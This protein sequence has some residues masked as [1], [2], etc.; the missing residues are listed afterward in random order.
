MV[1]ARILRAM[2]IAAVLALASAARPALAAGLSFADLPKLVALSA[3]QISPDGRSIVVVVRR[4]DYEHDRNEHALDIVDVATARHRTLTVGRKGVSSPAWSPQ[5]DR[6]AFLADVDDK[7]QIFVMPMNG[8]DAAR[9][10]NAAEGVEQFAWRPDG[11]AFA[12]VAIDEAP[13][14][15]G[16][17][18][19][20]DAFKV[21]NNDYLRRHAARSGHIY[22]VDAS[23]G[24]ARR[25]TR[26]AWSVLV[27]EPSST[28]SWSH[29]GKTIAFAR[30][31]NAI[32]DTQDFS[33]AWLVD[34]A[35]GQMHPLTRHTAWERDPLFSAD[36]TRVAFTYCEGD[37]QVNPRE[38]YVT[39]PS[40]GAETN[41]TRAVDRAVGDFA[42]LPDN[43]AL[44]AGVNDGTANA[45]FRVPL[46]GKAARIDLHGVAIESSLDGAIAKDGGIAFVGSTPAW[47]Q[48]VYYAP[49]GEAPRRLTDYNEAIARGGLSKSEALEYEGPDGFHED[50]VVTYPAGYVPGRRYPLVLI[51]HGGPTSAST[52]GFRYL[53]QL[54]AT[55][56]WFVLQPNYR[57]S[58][59]LGRAYQ[60]A[61]LYDVVGG[62]GRDVIA[63]VDALRRRGEID[64][65]RIGVSGWSY[66]GI[67][68]SWMIT[69][70]HIW[71]AALSGAGVHDWIVDYALAD[72]LSEDV[73]LF[74]GSPFTGHAAE[75]RAASPLTYA[76][77]IT[78]PLLLLSDVGD[79]R[80]P[81]PETY[82]LFRALT[83]LHKPVEFYAYPVNGHYPT[84]P[85]RVDDIARR[86]VGWF[87]SHF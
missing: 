81:I 29:D 13:K 72:D 86:W 51:I 46:E 55:R 34:A 64:D 75:W 87:A 14:P 22:L 15:K 73:D 8:G 32:A 69:H 45:V 21:A 28:L 82:E 67:M 35:S 23:G 74:H 61:I 27:G 17:D 36:G 25:L 19:Y 38:L 24:R 20:R 41:L 39:P 85:V 3:P 44:Y 84:D 68:T 54:L 70:Y 1:R 48:E 26:G 59:N 6:L 5:G 4:A 60:R 9:V 11:A 76:Q 42:W 78:T 53:P 30:A 47:P 50:A 10:T 40:G 18:Q 62:P 66:G 16:T 71:R 33:T 7:S 2:S 37:S 80:V 49:P 77:Q 56:G 65:R 31:A 83:D 79:A 63:A 57:G 52:V 43:S 12:Y 58:D